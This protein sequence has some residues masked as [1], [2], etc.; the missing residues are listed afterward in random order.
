MESGLSKG[1]IIGIILGVGLSL[2]VAISL[3]F[4]LLRRRNARKTG[5]LLSVAT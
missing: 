1:A 3:V 5:R 4:V 2:V